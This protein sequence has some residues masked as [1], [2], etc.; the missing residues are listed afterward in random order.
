MATRYTKI[1]VICG[2]YNNKNDRN[3]LMELLHFYNMD[4]SE[5][6]VHILGNKVE[7]RISS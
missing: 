3:Q 7:G 4:R 1:L 6:M 5:T 2:E